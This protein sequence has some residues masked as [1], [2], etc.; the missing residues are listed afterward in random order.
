MDIEIYT[1]TPAGIADIAVDW[2]LW[3][4]GETVVSS[5]WSAP[6]LTIN[7]QSFASGIAVVYVG[8]GTAGASYTLVHTITTATRT[9]QQAVTLRVEDVTNPSNQF[10]DLIYEVR[11]VLADRRAPYR[12]SDEDLLAYANDAMAVLSNIQPGLFTTV[13][14]HRCAEGVVQRLPSASTLGISSILGLR[15]TTREL[16]ERLDPYWAAADTA[17]PQH[18]MPYENDRR[19]FYVT[20]PA[21]YGHELQVSIAMAPE[22]Y[23]LSDSFPVLRTFWPAVVDYVIGMA[24]ARDDEHVLNARAQQFMTKASSLMGGSNG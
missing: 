1:K 5:S 10:S 13:V 24:E 3:L 8:G 11:G 20:P 21:P 2:S 15:P 14:T 7:S 23:N 6:G 19:R 4:G 9:D 12:Y 18:W 22:R 16:I 17:A